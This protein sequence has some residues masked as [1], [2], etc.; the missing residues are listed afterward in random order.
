MILIKPAGFVGS[1]YHVLLV[2]SLWM[3]VTIFCPK[4]GVTGNVWRH[5]ILTFHT[6]FAGNRRK[7]SSW[8]TLQH[9]LVDDFVKFTEDIGLPA[10][11][12]FKNLDRQS[13]HKKKQM[14]ID[15]MNNDASNYILSCTVWHFCRVSDSRKMER[16]QEWALS[17]VYCDTRSSC[18]ELL[19]KAKLTTLGCRRSQDIA[20]IMYKAK[21]NMPSIDKGH[22]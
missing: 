19:R 14:K 16:V 20:I 1:L 5:T 17:A 22:F 18:D 8:N 7:K 3:F 6:A 13:K 4:H 21:Y 11:S 9:Y 2:S 12:C 15:V 10:I